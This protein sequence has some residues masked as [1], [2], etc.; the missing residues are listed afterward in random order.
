MTDVLVAGEQ[1]PVGADIAAETTRSGRE[2]MTA[3]LR[4]WSGRM[5]DGHARGFQQSAAVVGPRVGHGR[6]RYPDP[7]GQEIAHLRADL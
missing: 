2:R 5:E 1:S 7:I 6:N 4:R 3:R